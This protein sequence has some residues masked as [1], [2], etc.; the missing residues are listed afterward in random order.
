[1]NQRAQELHLALPV[2]RRPTQWEGSG[3]DGAGSS[4]LPRRRSLPGRVDTVRR[5]VA[6]LRRV[7]REWAIRFSPPIWVWPRSSGGFAGEGFVA[8]GVGGHGALQQPVEEQ[9]AMA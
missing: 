4:P 6:V 3:G 1:M 8:V 5:D 2:C 9:P 7:S